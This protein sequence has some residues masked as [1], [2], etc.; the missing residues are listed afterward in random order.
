MCTTSTATC[1]RIWS[2]PLH[3]S[4]SCGSAAC[5]VR[6]PTVSSVKPSEAEQ[7]VRGHGLHCQGYSQH[8]SVG[9][10]RTGLHGWCNGEHSARPMKLVWSG[11]GLGHEAMKNCCLVIS[12]RS[13]QELRQHPILT[14]GA[15]CYPPHVA[16][17]LKGLALGWRHSCSHPIDGS[18]GRSLSA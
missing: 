14:I 11:T 17:Y 13:G 18:I 8:I 15:L 1:G 5:E 6:A 3:S 16:S 4:C 9:T 7:D 12:M 2:D 10:G